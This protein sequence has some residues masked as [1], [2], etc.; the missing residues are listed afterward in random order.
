MLLVTGGAGFIGSVITAT[1]NAEGRDDIIIV[2]SLHT[3][4]KWQ[5]L[6]KKKFRDLLHKDDLL[7]L[8]ESNAFGN[9][10]TGII[11]MGACSSTTETDGDYLL[12]NNYEYSKALGLYAAK[13]GIRFVYA[14]SAATYGAGEHGYLENFEPLEQLQPLNRYGFS[15]Q[16]FDLWAR[17]AIPK[18]YTGLKFFN[19]YGPNEYHKGRMASVVFHAYHQVLE[20]KE[21]KLFRSYRDDYKDG[22]Q[23]RDFVYVKD[24]AKVVTWLLENPKHTGLFNVGNGQARTWN[25]LAN[26]LFAA[27]NTK[28]QIQYIDMP[29]N[30][31]NQ[32]Q[33]FT[34]AKMERLPHEAFPFKFHSLEEGVQNYVQ[35][36]L[37]TKDRYL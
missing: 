13:R 37:A 20:N 31:I 1:L 33:Y 34:E 12:R 5:N 16:I 3:S 29:E 6:T 26:A 23:M 21:I 22:E 10:I 11:H 15:K 28:P 2:D 9:Q 8:L 4:E 18:T 25:D 14:S 17:Q 19:V 36:H 24:V 32:Y 7:K 35:S 27:L 30:L